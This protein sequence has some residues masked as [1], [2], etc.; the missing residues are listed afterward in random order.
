MN[1]IDGGGSFFKVIINV[2]NCNE[3]NDL[4]FDL[5]SGVQWSQFLVIIEDISESHLT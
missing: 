1:S 2:F 5:N 3:K 4:N